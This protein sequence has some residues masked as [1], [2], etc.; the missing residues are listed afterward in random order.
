[1]L[2]ISFLV[3]M[4][5]NWNVCGV[6]ELRN[7]SKQS[8]I[9]CS[10]CE[11]GLCDDCKEH[12]SLSKGTRNHETV[13][14]HE[15]QKLPSNVIQIAQSCRKHDQ[16]YQI[17]CKKHDCPCCKRCVVE[18]HN[19]CEDLKDIDDVIDGI[20][21]SNAFQDIEKTL[22]E[23]KEHIQRIRKD[24]EENL[25]SLK[26]QKKNIGMEIQKAKTSINNHL[27]QLHQKLL[28]DL[29]ASEEK[30]NKKIRQL[31]SEVEKREKEI[32]EFQAGLANIKQYASDL[33]TFL[34]A[35][36]MERDLAKKE[37]FV[38]SI[39]KSE[40]LNHPQIYWK[41][42]AID[43]KSFG[44]IIVVNEPNKIMINR[45]K[46]QQAQQLIATPVPKSIDNLT[47]KLRQTVNTNATNVRGCT[48]LPDGRMMFTC[49][50]QHKVIAINRDGTKDF[51]IKVDRS[52]DILYEGNNIIVV[53]SGCYPGSNFINFIDIET[54]KVAKKLDVG[55][56]NE[57]AVLT[58]QGTL[59]YCAR[60]NGL[61]TID[62]KTETKGSIRSGPLSSRVYSYVTILNEHILYTNP[63][64][65][66]VTCSDFQ[67]K[68][69]WKFTEKTVF[70]GPQGISVDKD[71][72]VYVAGTDSNN[73]V[74]V[75]H[76]EEGLCDECKDHHSLFKGS[77]NH[78]TVTIAE[79]QRLPSN[80]TQIAQSC[81]KHDQKYQIFCKKHDCPC[82]KRCVVE[83]HNKCEVLKDI[84][85]VIGGI[86]SS[87]TFQD[88]EKT[89]NEIKEH[90][91]IIRKD[92]EENL[93]SLKEQKKHIGME[94]QKAKTTIN[95][96]LDK[97]HQAVLRDLDA[98][99]ETENKK[100]R[101][102]LSEVEKREKEITEFLAGLANIK[103]YASDLQTFLTAKD[104]E[105]DLAKKEFFYSQ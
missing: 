103:Q 77:R 1:M 102:S 36:D 29:D 12:H 6:C 85:D 76:D 18:D 105:R 53:T 70:K 65:N 79:Y 54:R 92:R 59:I 33:Q 52:F 49:Y 8:V 61:R 90:I 56:Y 80:V 45:Q 101:Q 7:I 84:D 13:T 23:V 83:D 64:S 30:E 11:E 66:T 31:L 9:W 19:K 21:S 34:A 63:D 96:H 68:I 51:E 47:L 75:S 37:N 17:L 62:L 22:N 94:I 41:N 2:I 35:K 99:E 25:D 27:D 71:G 57:G 97:L 15:Y 72:N 32:T 89:L 69:Q 104:M 20:K 10:D 16:K 95:N 88:I 40:K 60:E 28:R 81:R 5:S 91:Q 24:R 14:I 43:I 73:V 78:D 82:C 67:G 38:Q 74:V 44:E 46:D 87:N 42:I 50:L 48:I 39:I 100:I 55:S 58:T 3:R 86:K 26:E 4:A 93:A 98:S